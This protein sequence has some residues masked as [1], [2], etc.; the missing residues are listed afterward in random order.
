MTPGTRLATSSGIVA[1]SAATARDPEHVANIARAKRFAVPGALVWLTSIPLHVVA[2][3]SIAKGRLLDLVLLSLGGAFLI[4]IG[5]AR[6]SLRPPSPRGWRVLMTGTF[7]ALN[8]AFGLM[9]SI[10]GG[11]ASPYFGGALVVLAA[12]GIVVT[13]RWRDGLGW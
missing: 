12:F 13:L 3:Q 9:G 2:A 11:V 4:L 8:V 6:M 5:L 1:Q 10:S 7:A